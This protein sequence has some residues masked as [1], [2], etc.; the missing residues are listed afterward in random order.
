MKENDN[1]SQTTADTQLAGDIIFD[2]MIH[3]VGEKN[4][5]KTINKE[6]KSI[7]ANIDSI[8]EL[9]RKSRLCTQL[10][11]NKDA[12]KSRSG[13][14]NILKE[15]GDAY[16]NVDVHQSHTTTWLGK[17]SH[18]FKQLVNYVAPI[19]LTTLGVAATAAG[20]LG[21]VMTGVPVMTPLGWVTAGALGTIGSLWFGKGTTK[22]HGVSDANYYNQKV[23]EIVHGETENNGVNQLK[24]NVVTLTKALVKLQ[25]GLVELT[26]EEVKQYCQKL[27]DLVGCI[28]KK[29][30]E[31]KIKNNNEKKSNVNI[32]QPNSLYN[33]N[34][35][36]SKNDVINKNNL[37]VENKNDEQINKNDQ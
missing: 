30:E 20:V 19:A 25:S 9:I 8:V 28:Q 11:S 33:N 26:D 27:K 1:S 13:R 15:A 35:K 21:T 37:I 36:N 23:K 4:D 2:I 7:A 10:C 31:Q 5:P 32:N 14:K 34:I 16:R 12:Y 6:Y 18:K 29:E 24:E 3:R 17:I 22:H